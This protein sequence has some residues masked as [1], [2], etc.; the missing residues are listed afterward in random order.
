MAATFG[1]LCVAPYHH[2][3]FDELMRDMGARTK[4]GNPLV[5]YLAPIGPARYA[6]LLATA[7]GHAPAAKETA[8]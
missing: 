8:P 7:P 5:A 6:G 3:H 2:A 1:G 4:P